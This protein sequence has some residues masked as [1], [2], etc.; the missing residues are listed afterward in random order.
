MSPHNQIVVSR[1]FSVLLVAKRP[2]NQIILVHTSLSF[3][4]LPTTGKLRNY[5]VASA[6]AGSEMPL[7]ANGGRQGGGEEERGQAREDGWN[8]SLRFV[9]VRC[10]CCTVSI[11]VGASEFCLFLV[12]ICTLYQ[13]MLCVRT[14]LGNSSYS[15]RPVYFVYCSALVLKPLPCRHYCT[16]GRNAGN[17]TENCLASALHSI[18][19]WLTS[20]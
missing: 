7:Y 12:R 17:T 10:W 19:R 9:T 1:L 3:A 5:K 6:I 15:C 13:Y 8:T 11:F 18:L 16:V 2:V 4:P 20:V 14:C